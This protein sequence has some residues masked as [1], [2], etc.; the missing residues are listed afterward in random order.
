MSHFSSPDCKPDP[1]LRWASLPQAERDDAYDNNKAVTDSPAL[2][3]ARNEASAV[4]RSSRAS[5]LDVPYME[6]ERTKFDLYPAIDKAAPCLVF[7]HGGYWQRNSREL[8]AMMVEG[9]SEH[10]W[11]V[12]IMGYSLA[13]EAT[14]AQIA[15]EVTQ[16]LDWLAKEGPSFGIAGPLVL[17]GW[18]AGAHLTA[19]GLKHSAVVAG[20]AL[21]GLYDLAPIRDTNLNAALQLTDEEV[22]TLSPLKL[23]VVKKSLVIAYGADELPALVHDSQQFYAMRVA[24]DAPGDLIAIPNTN[25]FTILEELRRPYGLLV[26]AARKLVDWPN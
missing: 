19:I 14:M 22:A 20:L 3:A 24:A 18:S 9:M 7:I 26:T 15:H 10:G 17:S 23:P 16:A 8:F 21:S 25:H 11:S 13:P 1:R 2:I 4:L 6:G 5:A 12:A